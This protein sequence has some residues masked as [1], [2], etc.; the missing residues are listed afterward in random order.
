[1]RSKEEAMDYRYFPDPDLLPL[2]LEQAWIDGIKASLPELPDQ[3]RRRL[4]ADY[5]LTQYDA[6]V[7]ISEQAKADYFEE[8]AKGRDAK[9]VANWVT[10]ELSARLAAAGKDFSESPLPASHVA[11]LVALIEE[12][13]ISSKIAKEVFDHVW[14]G[15][16]SPSEVVEKHGLKQVTD[17]GAIER[18]V[19]EIIAANP[20]KAAAVAEK[21]QAIGWF[22]GQVMKATGGKANP[23]A[24]NDILKAKLGL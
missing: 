23:A 19:D 20:D 14:N 2:E 3:K 10:N 7:L 13:V 11:E 12:G 15:E 1:M 5:G 8:A 22:V 4:M 24:V 18:A 16:G 17:T 21:P 6:I 9:L